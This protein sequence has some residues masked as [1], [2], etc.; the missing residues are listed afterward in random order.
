MKNIGFLAGRLIFGGF[1]LYNGINHILHKDQ[2]APYADA[3]NVP[4]PEA[5]VVGTGVLLIASGL[6][7]VLGLKPKLGTAG[8]I[9]FLAGV[10]P[11]MHNFWIHE[12]AAQ[13]QNDLIHFMKNMAMLGAALA[14]LDVKKWPASIAN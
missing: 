2:L 1:F 6:S 4:M 5:A 10:S 9:A 3:K 13:R 8:V 7:V 12:D 14:L 11:A